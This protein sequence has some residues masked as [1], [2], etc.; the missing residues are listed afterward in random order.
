[1]KK[2]LIGLL[3]LATA[4]LNTSCYKH[5]PPKSK[6]IK[7]KTMGNNKGVQP[8]TLDVGRYW[9]GWYWD[10]Y[11]YPTNTIIYPFTKG[12]TEG[13]LV[14]EAFV[15]QDKD[16]LTCNVDIA[17]SAHANPNMLPI[18]FESYTGDMETIIKT[19]V[20]QDVGNR[21]ID[22]ASRYSAENLY[23]DKKMEMLEYVKAKVMEKYSPTGV[24]LDD[25]SY[26]S[27]IRLPEKL[28]QAINDKIEA[29]QL[30]LK[31]EAQ[32]QQSEAEAK[33]VKAKAQG[34][35]DAKLLEAEGNL[36]L[37]KS[38]TPELNNYILANKWNGVVSLYSGSGAV[39][40][41]LF[42]Y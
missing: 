13:S 12:E 6:G 24:I 1:M 18:I 40:P 39:L 20:R 26:K 41:P 4:F 21:F 33:K 37:A 16:G 17:V 30:A 32:L 29:T 11:I 34:E 28:M 3:L 27:D 7:V 25:V 14:D 2:Y 31:T 15:F 9:V 22:F 5:V 35:Y 19:Y 8:V 38:I 10:L 23:S 42:K 36:R